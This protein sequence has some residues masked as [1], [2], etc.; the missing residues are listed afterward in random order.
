MRFFP[1]L[2]PLL[3]AFATMSFLTVV[4]PARAA[5]APD[6]QARLAQIAQNWRDT[7]ARQRELS[8]M[9]GDTHMSSMANAMNR[10]NSATMMSLT[11]MEAMARNPADARDIV[12]A[13]L[14]AAPELAPEIKAG[15]ITAFPGHT[16]MIA[17]AGQQRPA[18]TAPGPAAPTIARAPQRSD[19]DPRDPLEGFNRA[20]FGV[21][22]FLDIVLLEPVSRVYRFIMPET[23]R[24]IARNFF[25]NFGEPVVAIN[26]LLQGDLDNAGVSLGRFAVNSTAGILGFFEVAERIDLPEHPADFGQTLHSYGVGDGSYLVLPILGPSTARDAVGQG[27]DLFLNPFYYLLEFETLLYLKAGELVVKREEA[28]EGV[29]KLQVTPP[30]YYSAARSAYFK[31]RALELRKTPKR[32]MPAVE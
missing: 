6:I 20:M 26:N 21:N 8:R 3:L 31:R 23:L 14:N 1:A 16:A 17:G 27:V 9:S 11:V 4:S 7:D 29:E 22:N 10:R 30:D 18:V 15:L 2:T 5:V 25:E 19:R 24:H 13:A 28:L 12:P 32:D